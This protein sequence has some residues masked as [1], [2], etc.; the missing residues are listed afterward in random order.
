MSDHP[1]IDPE[2]QSLEARLTSLPPRLP[3]DEQ[4]QLLY[5]CAFAAGKRAGQRASRRMIRA[6]TAV[7]FVLTLLCVG[8]AYRANVRQD[9]VPLAHTSPSYAIAEG[10][11]DRIAIRLPTRDAD[12]SRQLSAAT[13][14]DRAVD[15]N[16]PPQPPST[17]PSAGN[18]M[19]ESEQ[20]ML[21][22]RS[23]I[24]PDSI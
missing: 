19:S 8:L 12:D 5:E 11:R 7:S 24:S 3:A 1:W 20:P 21:T 4:K 23:R 13:A 6:S 14:I 22:S 9:S 18:R 15:F 17:Q 2:L 16:W 10:E